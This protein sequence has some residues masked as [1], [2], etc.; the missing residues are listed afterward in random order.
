MP[1]IRIDSPA[2][3]CA[4]TGKTFAPG[5]AVCSYLLDDKEAYRR[6]DII[7]SAAATYA[8]PCPVVCRWNWT[9]KP[10]DTRA[11]DEAR[12]TLDQTEAL[13]LALCDETA[14]TDTPD[15]DRAVLK[16]LLALALQ[17]KR[18]IKPV[19]NRPGEYA[20][21]ASGRIC[22]A[23]TPENLT[24]NILQRAAEKLA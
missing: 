3:T 1:E 20:H 12:T 19:P 18:I 5:D 13:F 4:A 9:V 6:V 17:R 10:R 2:H 11:S 16:Y 15:T 7:Q 24:A 23:P 22:Q 14:Y 21:A 8:P